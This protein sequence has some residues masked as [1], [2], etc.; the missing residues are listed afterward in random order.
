MNCKKKDEMQTSRDLLWCY[1]NKHVVPTMETIQKMVTVYHKQV[2]DILK[3]Y[4]T[5]STFVCTSLLVNYFIP[6]KSDKE[7]QE[8]IRE[9]MVAGH[10]LVF[11]RKIVDDET[12]ICKSSYICESIVEVETSQL[13]PHFLCLPM[14]TSFYNRFE[15]EKNLQSFKH[16]KIDKQL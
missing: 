6:S 12:L 16:K 8:T 14:P 15:F 9:D 1:N 4:T 5:S 7:L 10:S 2:F 3:F 11:T 13:Y